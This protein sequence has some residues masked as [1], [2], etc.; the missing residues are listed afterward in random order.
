GC[1]AEGG[2]AGQSFWRIPDRGQAIHFALHLARPEDFV[3]VA[4]KG[5]EQSMCFITTEYPWDDIHATEA[6]LDA[7]LA[8]EPMPNLGLPTFDPNF[9]VPD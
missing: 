3:L 5:H 4:G 1:E 2:V 9:K 6:A 7:F 8:G